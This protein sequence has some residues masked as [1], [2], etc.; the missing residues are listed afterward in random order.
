VAHPRTSASFRSIGSAARSQRRI[1]GP[2]DNDQ[3]FVFTVDVP[4][5]LIYQ[6][7]Q[8]PPGVVEP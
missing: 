3:A 7:L 2:R 5:G 1:S 4:L 8:P 6:M